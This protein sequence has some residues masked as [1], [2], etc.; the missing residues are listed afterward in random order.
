MSYEQLDEMESRCKE[1]KREYATENFSFDRR[2][3]DAS[4][5]AA[6]AVDYA[7]SVA[8]SKKHAWQDPI[9]YFKKIL[10]LQDEER[11][12]IYIR[13]TRGSVDKFEKFINDLKGLKNE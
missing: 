4:T 12:T 3:G 8:M 5:E 11:A 1:L 6:T 7:H 10:K 2:F 13:A 9:F